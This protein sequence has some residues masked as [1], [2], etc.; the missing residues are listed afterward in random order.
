M[1]K[2]HYT[3]IK[4]FKIHKNIV[5]RSFY[6]YITYMLIL[7]HMC[8]PRMCAGARRGQKTSSDLVGLG[9]QA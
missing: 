1:I 4:G 5:L 6:F 9:L 3:C 7:T 2:T 8:D